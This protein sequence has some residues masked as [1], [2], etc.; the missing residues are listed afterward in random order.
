M[1]ED[2]HD[3]RSA[4]GRRL[5]SCAGIVALCAVAWLLPRTAVG[6]AGASR[7]A[8][9]VA[10]REF[11]RVLRLTG[12]TE[13]VT[14]YTAIVPLLSGATRGSLTVVR[15]AAPGSLVRPG[16]LL[17]EFD[18]QQQDKL[19]FDKRVEH[20]T[21]VE[22]IA[23]KRAEQD[24]ARVKDESELAQAENAVKAAE[25]E[26]LKNEMLS[27]IKAE[28][29][30]QKLAE[31]K[32]TLDALSSGF[33]LKREAARAELRILEIKRDRAASAA[34]HAEQNARSMRMA[35]PIEGLVVPKTT[36][37]GNG[38]GDI[39]EGDDLWPGRGV[40]QVVGRG[41][42]RVRAKVSQADIGSVAVGQPAR[43]R[44]DAYPGLE[45]P[46]RVVQIGPVA[47]PGAFSPRV[48]A[49]TVLVEVAGAH[50]KLLPD[51]SAAVDV[52]VERVRDA[53]VV[54]RSAITVKDGRPHVR[55]A[56]GATRE[57]ALGPFDAMEA[58]VLEGL[59]AGDEVQP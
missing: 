2:V 33:P 56:G 57:V 10:P 39:R 52:E 22:Q 27:R 34:G 9:R 13:A 16:D 58:V 50:P 14:S 6:Q 1:T 36:W 31:A 48:R 43:V 11:A 12:L 44:L 37:K 55:L 17:V 51:L 20:T 42:M 32:A 53:L 26:V 18:R 49:F 41:A 46:G 23:R 15:I 21:L 30:E 45:M 38:M 29:N 28:Q 24:A 47:Q 4:R 19:A 54:P 7:G 8:V 59:R 3:H 40:L 35:S 5:V 25:L